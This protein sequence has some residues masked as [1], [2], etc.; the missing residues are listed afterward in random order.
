MPPTTTGQAPCPELAESAEVGAFEI[1]IDANWEAGESR[2]YELTSRRNDVGEGAD[3]SRHLVTDIQI[4]V[5]DA[6]DEGFVLEW[7]YGESRLLAPAEPA[8]PELETALQAPVGLRVEYA[9]DRFGAYAEL[10]NGEEVQSFVAATLKQLLQTMTEAGGDERAVQGAQ[11]MVEQLLAQPDALE[12]LFLQEIQ[13]FHVLHGYLFDSPEPIRY[14]DLLPNMLGGDPIP[15]QVTIRPTRYSDAQ[16]CARIEWAN[17]IDPN[18]ARESIVEGLMAQ[19]ERLGIELEPPEP[20]ELPD[21]FNIQDEMQ[22]D[23]DLATAWPERISWQ[24]QI[25]IGDHRR[26]DERTIVL[27]EGTTT[28]P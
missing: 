25:Q 1:D 9:T 6:T 16:G 14:D 27:L 26:T 20:G 7:V 5:L 13:L 18:K 23:L 4:T 11:Q 19:A 10:R 21:A 8:S 24:R 22:F 12:T 28:N 3:Q 15:S 17:A 2:R